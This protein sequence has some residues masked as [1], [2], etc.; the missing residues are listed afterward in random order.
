[1]QRK[2]FEDQAPMHE[3]YLGG[4]LDAIRA[5]GLAGIID[6]ATVRAW[7]QIDGGDPA[8][9]QAGNGALLFREQHDIIDR[10]YVDMREHSPPSG[11]V[12]TYLLTLAGTPAIP[13]AKSYCDVFP[14]ILRAPISRR[15][16]LALRTP[17]AAGNLALFTNRWQLIEM[18]TLPVYQRLIAERAAEAR[19]LI[20]RP[21][22]KRVRPWGAQTRS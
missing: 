1:M 5:L 20:E 11:R 10:F 3:A 9:V 6:S 4:G 8:Q 19:A 21:I 17:L 2:I 15:A 7:E 18:D 22:A 12:F 13:G 16:R 14:L